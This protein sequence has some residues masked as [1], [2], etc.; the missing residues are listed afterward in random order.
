MA[1]RWISAALATAYAVRG[2]GR[3]PVMDEMITQEAAAEP[4]R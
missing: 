4:F 3:M 2:A 1:A